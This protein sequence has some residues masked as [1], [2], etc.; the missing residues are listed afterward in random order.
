MWPDLGRQAVFPRLDG[1]AESQAFI[2]FWLIC[3]PGRND[4]AHSQRSFV[5]DFDV[6]IV[7]PHEKFDQIGKE[8]F[9][10]VIVRLTK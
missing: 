2:I 3:Q 7:A 4:F 6:L 9:F 5:F 8:R 10:L 1:F